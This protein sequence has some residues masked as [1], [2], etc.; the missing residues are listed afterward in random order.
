MLGIGDF[1]YELGVKIVEICLKLKEQT[2]GLV[3]ISTLKTRLGGKVEE[4]D[5]LRAIDSLKPLGSGFKVIK[6]GGHKMVQSVPREL[7]SDT[8]ALLDFAGDSGHFHADEACQRL[9]WSSERTRNAVNLLI[10][11]GLVWIDEQA[12]PKSFWIPGLFS[13][14]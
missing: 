11:E 2:G 8:T 3:D 10:D 13:G 5:I 9:G 1:Y 7:S 12:Q 6:I 4:D 14:I